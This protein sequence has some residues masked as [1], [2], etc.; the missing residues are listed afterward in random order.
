M[1]TVVPRQREKEEFRSFIRRLYQLW[2]GIPRR[3]NKYCDKFREEG[4]GAAV[5]AS[6]T[7]FTNEL[8]TLSNELITRGPYV[9]H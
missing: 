7:E 5:E 2:G 8:G 3:F 9:V 4:E 6:E 1:L